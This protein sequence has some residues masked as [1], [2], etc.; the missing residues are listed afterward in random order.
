[1]FQSSITSLNISDNEI[2]TGGALVLAEML[3]TQPK[4]QDVSNLK[5]LWIGGNPLC[6]AS[7]RAGTVERYST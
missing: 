3:K 2:D 1:M 7:S 6:S 4:T 5:A